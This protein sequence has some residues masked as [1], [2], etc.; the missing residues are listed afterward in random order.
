MINE[1]VQE[2]A[3]FYVTDEAQIEFQQKTGWRLIPADIFDIHYPPEVITQRLYR[4]EFYLP[5]ELVLKKGAGDKKEYLLP[6]L[7]YN[8]S[9]LGHYLGKTSFKA[10]RWINVDEMNEKQ[11]QAYLAFKNRKKNIFFQLNLELNNYA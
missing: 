4:K 10:F 11:H 3:E 6:F 5:R 2:L 7:K 1:E 9:W 8:G